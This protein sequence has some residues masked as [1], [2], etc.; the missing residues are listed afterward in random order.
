L[1]EDMERVSRIS[2]K[3]GETIKDLTAKTLLDI[4]KGSRRDFQYFPQIK[5]LRN[6]HCWG[7]NKGRN[8]EYM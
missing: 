8:E 1:R 5:C 7:F 3:P 6:S 2:S 4:L